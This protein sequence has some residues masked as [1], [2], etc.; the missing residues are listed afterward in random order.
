MTG[1]EWNKLKARLEKCPKEKREKAIPLDKKYEIIDFI[2]KKYSH[3]DPQIRGTS[4]IIYHLF[5]WEGMR[6]KDIAEIL[7]VSRPNVS[8]CLKKH[9]AR[10]TSSKTNYRVQR[11]MQRLRD[12]Y[13][14]EKKNIIKIIKRSK[15]GKV[16]I[17][18]KQ[19]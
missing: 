3:Q 9:M 13:M 10:L 14:K 15:N 18:E 6:Q 12:G 8:K 16:E 11:N 17:I 4:R 5:F 7:C 1:K 19:K 2:I